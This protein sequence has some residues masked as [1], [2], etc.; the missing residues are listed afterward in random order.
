MTPTDPT[1][2]QQLA[3]R[4]ALHRFHARYPCPEPN[5]GHCHPEAWKQVG[6]CPL[7]ICLPNREWD[8]LNRGTTR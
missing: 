6:K 2:R 5:T 1:P 3:V 7:D 8:D 4:F